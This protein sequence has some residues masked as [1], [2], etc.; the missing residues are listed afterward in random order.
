GLIDA[1]EFYERIMGK[2]NNSKG[3]D[4]AMSFTQMSTNVL[5]EPYKENYAN[6]YEKGALI[7]M[8]LDII[9][10]EQSQGEKGVLWMMQQLSNKYGKNVPFEDADLMDE[11]VAMTYP[12]VR[13]FFDAHVIGDT[14]IDYGT[15]FAKVGLGITESEKQTGYFLDGDMPFIDV[16]QKNNNAIYV[17]KGI[18]LNTFFTDLGLQ[19]GDVIK[20]I[21]GTDI[22]LEAIRGVIGQSFGWTP[23]TDITMVVERDGQEMEISGKVGT[24]MAKEKILAPLDSATAAQNQLRE[25]WMKG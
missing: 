22:D 10:R 2:I 11:I 13:S 15:F 6:V 25:A 21:N 17:R 8:C 3:Y 12:E 7:N 20:K 18:D 5:D 24:P 1:A 16:D 19:G 9:L 4:D 23:D 14:P